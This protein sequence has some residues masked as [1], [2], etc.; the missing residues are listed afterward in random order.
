MFRNIA[1]ALVIGIAFA[2]LAAEERAKGTVD[3]LVVSCI[4][5]RLRTELNENMLEHYGK[6]SY[7]EIALAGASLGVLNDAFKGWTQTFRDNLDIAIKLHQVKKVIF[8]DHEDCGAYKQILKSTS[9]QTHEAQM[10]RVR[11]FMT[12]NYPKLEVETFI[13]HLDGKLV[14]MGETAHAKSHKDAPHHAD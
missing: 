2:T 5:F 1:C 13:L 14:P 8:V 9:D 7:D 10:K 11:E 3:N 12:K 4:D 6:D